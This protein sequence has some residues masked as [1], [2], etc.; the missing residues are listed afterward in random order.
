[1]RR[2]TPFIRSLWFG[3]VLAGL[4]LLCHLFRLNHDGLWID[5]VQTFDSIAGSLRGL[6]VNRIGA[7][8]IPTYFIFMWAWVRALGASEW[9]LRFPSVVFAA[10][11]FF[12][13]FLLV[14]QF[15]RGTW[16]YI[17]ALA[18]FF[19]HPFMLEASHTARMYSLVAA[20][21]ILAA[22]Q[23][24][25]YVRS[26]RKRFLAGY[27]LACLLGLSVH[28]I[29]ALQMAAHLAF[30]AFHH[31]TRLR[32]YLVAVVLPLVALGPV[33]FLAATR[34]R[35]Y[36]P[37]LR[38]HFPVLSMMIRKPNVL[39]ATDFGEN[40]AIHGKALVDIARG[41]NLAFFLWFIVLGFLRL[42]EMR[43]QAGGPD[44]AAAEG[45]NEASPERDLLR[46][47]FYWIGVPVFLLMMSQVFNNPK[48]DADRYQ[49]PSIGAA[50][51]VVAMG[52]AGAGHKLWGR[53]IN[54]AYVA[55]FGFAIV[56]QTAG[57]DPGIRESVRYIRQRYQE[58]DCVVCCHA[59][60]GGAFEL[61]D[62]RQPPL[63]LVDRANLDSG[64][65]L[66]QI[67]TFA[68][69]KKRLWVFLHHAKQSPLTGLL[70]GH[71]EAFAPVEAVTARE[72]EVRLFQV[73]GAPGS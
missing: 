39:I 8:H 44:A 66:D 7:G 23:L 37:G 65:L 27:G 52:L 61:Y 26:G 72:T 54:L 28:M 12:A 34:T 16:T 67:R 36:K 6:I 58:G 2:E 31:R 42:R 17:V 5:E 13:F 47:S 15:L 19:F 14:R 33:V 57:T 49:L 68:R 51:V 25:L 71:G 10:L 20:A 63:L 24:L 40:L 3:A 4:F 30:A 55:F 53:A 48:I 35:A 1:M 56:V 21:A 29:F 69:G 9:S 62:C 45:G 32:A 59:S 41:L 60:L 38:L 73:L 18:L 64:E 43:R 70:E 11:A 46:L 50:V 22:H